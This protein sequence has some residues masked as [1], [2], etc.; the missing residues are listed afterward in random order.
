MSLKKHLLV[1]CGAIV[2]PFM[3]MH[4]GDVN[5][6]L[7]KPVVASSQQKDFPAS[8]VT[9]GVV[10]RKSTWMSG[11]DSRPPHTLELNLERYYDIN[12]IVIHTGIPEAERTEQEKG[13]APGFWSMKNFKI[14]YWDDAN[15]TDLPDTERTENR[16]DKL[17]FT[18]NPQLTTFRIRL[19]STD[20][21]PIAV[22]EFEVYGEEKK[23]MPVPVTVGEVSVVDDKEPEKDIQVT[24]TKD[25]IGKTMKYVAYNQGYYMPGS[26]V[27]GWLEYSNVNSLR[28]WTSMSDYVPEEAVLV[29]ENLDTLEGFEAY[30]NELRNDPEKNGFI[31]WE[32]ILERCRKQQFTTNSMV[33]EY[34]LEE[35]KRLNIDVVLQINTT[36]FDGTWSNK[37][38]QWQRFYA[39][40]FYAAKTGDVTMFAMHNEPNHRH[41]GPMKIT[42]YV[43]AMKIVSD[44]VYCAV[45]DVNRLYG[46][47][48][49]SRFVSPVTAGSNANWWAEVVKSLRIDYR[50]L[51]SDR[52]LIDIFSTHSYNLP[53]AGYVSK[54]SDI[55]KIIMENH[56]LEQPLPIVYTE[57]GRWMNAYL[58][59]KYETMDSPSL[60]TEWAGEYTNNTLN[61]GYGMWAFKFANTTSGTY[62]R[63]IKS[64]H[65]FIWQGK[66]IVEDAYK[67]VALG[68]K[69]FDLTSSI[70]VSTKVIT[71]GN[72][73]DAST[74]TSPDTD[75]EKCLEIN[76]GKEYSLGGAVVYTGSEYGVYTGPDRVKNFCLQ[77]WDG[78]RW[79]EIEGTGE[80]NARYT[81]SFFLFNTP[82]NTSKVRF[83]ATD[84]GSIK[85]R[86]IKLFEAESLKNIPVSYD[87]S[88]IQ[89]TGEVVRLFAKGFKNERPL[90]NTVKSVMDNDVDV[91]TSFN[92]EEMRYYVWLVQRK[93]SL[94]SL[95]LDLKSLN[96]PTGTR[97]FAEE[98]SANAYG[99][100]VWMKEIP[101]NGKLTFELPSQSVILLTIPVCRNM[102]ETLVATADAVIKSGNNREKNF[103]KAK[104]M[105]I[106]MDASNVN[107]N[108]ACYIKF[109]LSKVDTVNAALFQ[110]YGHSL[111][112]SPYRFHVYTLDNCTWDEN[113]LNWNNAPN[114]DKEQVRITGVG[115]TAHV[116]GEIVVGG[117]SSCHQLDVT[118]L[119]RSCKRKEITF[120]LI[121][122]LRHSG[123]DLDKNRVCILGTKES[124]YKPI[125]SVW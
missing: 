78:A 115:N 99:E 72:K 77:Y 31:Q 64:G 36:D 18:F 75:K 125:L 52:D 91:I 60:F 92:P 118:S 9:D 23:G 96:L 110:I 50:G 15:W 20:G 69:V 86:E 82:V 32:P 65:H 120:V 80:K 22:N 56:P 93:H 59:D 49:K 106:A 70:P 105:N 19:V 76:L 5:I 39:L 58:I 122:E 98:V 121:R 40:A 7:R 90:L 42:Q 1:A 53:A 38:K 28:V 113:S 33:F 107:C 74:W 111:D 13:K 103:G 44:A 57:T 97:A 41:A 62:P 51:P 8:N 29:D 2:M 24:V 112:K 71:D 10:S 100:V 123:D 116:A 61:Q 102:V 108:Q 3:A 87:V 68:K 88:G 14:Q 79:M 21:E 81:Q 83:I 67:N 66:R 34:A 124:D 73:S 114:L 89:R 63:G 95:T 6:A 26:N 27:S 12:R 117:N 17:E 119:I 85:V 84:R 30:K 48:L 45:Q 43:D 55:R 94:N 47:H 16:L 25:V 4:A 104:V 37:W 54:V 109:D 35:L 46:K 11:K 101:D